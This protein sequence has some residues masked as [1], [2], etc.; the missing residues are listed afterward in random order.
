STKAR[1]QQ[2]SEQLGKTADEKIRVMKQAE[3]DSIKADYYRRKEKLEAAK[4]AADIRAEAV[5]FGV[6]EVV[7]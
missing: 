2:V 1:L 3:H 5:A 6:M 4:G 7:Q